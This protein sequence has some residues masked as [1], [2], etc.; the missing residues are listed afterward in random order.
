[1]VIQA[2]T[3]GDPAAN[4]ILDQVVRLIAINLGG[5][6]NLLD[7]EIIVMGGG[8]VNAIPGFIQRLRSRIRDFLM[9]DEAKQDLRIEIETFSNSA[10]FGAAGDF[11]L[12]EGIVNEA[13]LINR[14]GTHG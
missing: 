13:A 8:V 1:M 9:T 11:F 12:E 6:V 10:L 14:R 7:L 3:A 5:V 2:S 4:A